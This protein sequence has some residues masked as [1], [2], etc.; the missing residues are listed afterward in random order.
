MK[1]GKTAVRSVPPVLANTP[2]EAGHNCTHTQEAM[3]A[4]G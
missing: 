2:A 3:I 1:D 4:H